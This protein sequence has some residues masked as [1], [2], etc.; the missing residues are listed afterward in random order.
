M[1]LPFTYSETKLWS[2]F[3][4]FSSQPSTI[5]IKYLVLVLS[6]SGLV[7]VTVAVVVVVVVVTSNDSGR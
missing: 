3:F 6:I 1:L 7:V 2:V 5:L 4:H